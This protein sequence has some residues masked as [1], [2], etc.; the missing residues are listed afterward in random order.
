MDCVRVARRACGR[1]D[2]E[3]SLGMAGLEQS[4]QKSKCQVLQV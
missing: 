2:F 3:P 1:D 4:R